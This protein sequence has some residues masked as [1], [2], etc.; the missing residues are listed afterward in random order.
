MIK[1]QKNRLFMKKDFT[2]NCQNNWSKM[3][4]TQNQVKEKE[5]L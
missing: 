5:T 1:I 2:N 4:T 3:K